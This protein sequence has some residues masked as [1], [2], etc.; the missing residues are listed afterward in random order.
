MLIHLRKILFVLPLAKKIAFCMLIIAAASCSEINLRG[1]QSECKII[2]NI[3]Y[4]SAAS[5]LVAEQLYPQEMVVYYK[6][7]KMKTEISSPLGLM[8][9]ELFIDHEKKTLSQTLKNISSYQYIRLSPE[10]T[11]HWC[12][13]LPQY[14]ITQRID[15]RRICNKDCRHATIK[16]LS[17]SKE[18]EVYYMEESGLAENNW[19]NPMS[20]ITGV[21]MSYDIEQMGMHM[22]LEARE[23][24]QEK[25]PDEI[26]SVRPEYKEISADSM[27]SILEK[28]VHDYGPAQ[29]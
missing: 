5:S 22:H 29:E 20:K 15:I 11:Q 7:D 10:E 25:I 28:L 19:W 12:S 4:P 2:Y 26:F 1:H 6:G 9:T 27:R 18:F 14:E 24:I 8:A 3:T 21:M 13:L 17:N 16:D 23:I